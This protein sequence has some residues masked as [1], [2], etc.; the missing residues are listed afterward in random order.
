M[1]VAWSVAKQLQ[2]FNGFIG[3]LFC[4]KLNFINKL[5]ASAIEFRLS[6]QLI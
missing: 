5:G 2:E 6:A 1:V 4:E 3:R